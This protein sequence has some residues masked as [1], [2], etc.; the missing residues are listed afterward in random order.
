MAREID[1]GVGV[2]QELIQ[3]TAMHAGRI[4]GIVSNAAGR[5]AREVGDFA[6]DVRDVTRSAHDTKTDTDTD[7]D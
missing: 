1:R 2:A 6:W 4:V 7:A 3:A 5:V